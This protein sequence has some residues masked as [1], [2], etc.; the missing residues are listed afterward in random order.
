MIF[1]GSKQLET[2]RLILRKFK[3][4]DSEKMFDSWVTDSETTKY[5][6][7]KPHKDISETRE[8]LNHWISNYENGYYNWVV[9]LKD[10]HELIG[11]IAEVIKNKENNTVTLGYCY[12]SKY[13]NKGYA[14]EALRCVIEYLLNNE[15][16]YLV[17][18][19]HRSSNPASG[20]VMQKAGM[21]YD[22][23]LRERKLNPDGTRADN[24]YYSIKKDEL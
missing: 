9:E 5:L 19:Y 1:N 22:G 20:K 23:T 10:T 18:A 12:G 2:E 8:I 11:N 15:G 14:S 6:S 24:I 7:W 13:W 21:K 4:E 3:I 16:F 17:E